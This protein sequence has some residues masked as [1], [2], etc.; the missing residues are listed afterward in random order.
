[1]CSAVSGGSLARAGRRFLDIPPLIRDSSVWVGGQGKDGDIPGQKMLQGG[2]GGAH[3][4][5]FGKRN[6]LVSVV[7]SVHQCMGSDIP[8][9]PFPVE[10]HLWQ[11][12]DAQRRFLGW[13]LQAPLPFWRSGMLQEQ[14]RDPPARAGCDPGMEQSAIPGLDPRWG[15]IHG[16]PVH[17]GEEFQQDS[18][19]QLL[20]L[21]SQCHVPG[22]A[23]AEPSVTLGIPQEPS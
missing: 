20:S 15:W 8:P 11:V 10:F 12:E 14:S 18:S 22:P 6:V 2:S 21:C 3:A 16:F 13:F 9:K 7:S 5:I 17:P 23:R 4:G 1:M 19:S